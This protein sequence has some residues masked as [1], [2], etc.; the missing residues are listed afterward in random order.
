MASAKNT[1]NRISFMK[2]IIVI[3][4]VLVIVADVELA[5]ATSIVNTASSLIVRNPLGASVSV[6]V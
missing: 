5:S 6:R 4:V 2:K 3:V 1:T